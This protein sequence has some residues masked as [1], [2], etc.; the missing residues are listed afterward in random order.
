MKY[1]KLFE[2]YGSGVNSTLIDKL[3]D[4]VIEKYFNKHLQNNDFDE[5][6]NLW[7]SIVWNNINDD[8]AM[9]SIKSDEINTQSAEDFSDYQYIEYINGKHVEIEDEE[10]IFNKYIESEIDLD[11][12]KDLKMELKGETDEDSKKDLRKQIRKLNK[13]IRDIK[14]MTLSEVLNSMSNDDLMD[15]IRD[16]FDEYDFV[17]TTVND[18]YEGYSLQ[19][20][21]ED[22]WGSVDSIEFGGAY[23]AKGDWD[24]ILQY[25]D[26][27]AVIKENNENET[28]EYK[29][30]RV[31]EELYRSKELQTKILEVDSENSILLYDLF[32]SES[33]DEQ[34]SDEFE[35]Q[36]SYIE[37]Y[38]KN[39]VDDGSDLAEGKAEA[40][41]NLYDNFDLSGGI[42]EEYPDNMFYVH[43]DKYNL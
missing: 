21:V 7:P 36:K 15:I 23:N 8:R 32:E 18:R 14:K 28:Y 9:D 22:I 25:V 26:E 11:E 6:I 12:L 16:I 40:I 35:F 33:D 4:D 30:E 39:Y 5:I 29:E 27:D 31:Q 3:D 2:S 13:K 24:W 42:E 17:E 41:K 43:A 10:S 38:A 34:I 20:Y 1:I 37:A 19:D